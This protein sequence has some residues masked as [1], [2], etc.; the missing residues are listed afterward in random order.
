M[1]YYNTRGNNQQSAQLKKRKNEVANDKKI[2]TPNLMGLMCY[3]RKWL[4]STKYS[5]F[6][7]NKQQTC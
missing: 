3:N 6:I 1:V 4:I 7:A 5:R 2:N